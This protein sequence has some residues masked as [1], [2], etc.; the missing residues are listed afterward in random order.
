MGLNNNLHID[1]FVQERQYS[2]LLAMELHLSCI[3]PITIF[4]H[5]LEC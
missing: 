3:N 4:F 5:S 2:S 1:V